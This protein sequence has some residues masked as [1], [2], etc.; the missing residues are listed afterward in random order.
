MGAISATNPFT[1]LSGAETTA[2]TPQTNVPS[3]GSLANTMKV[4]NPAY[5]PAT[6]Y[7]GAEATRNSIVVQIDGKAVASALQDSS[8]S[9][10][11]SSV[12]RLNRLL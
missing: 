11:G 8:L 4:L 9:G 6:G 3:A 7:S 2:R 1:G 5:T 10:I 12:N